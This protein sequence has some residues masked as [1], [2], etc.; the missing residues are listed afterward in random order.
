MLQV[1]QRHDAAAAPAS[2]HAKRGPSDGKLSA[3]PHN[4]ARLSPQQL[5]P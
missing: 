4:A 5:P 1:R 2:V 3:P